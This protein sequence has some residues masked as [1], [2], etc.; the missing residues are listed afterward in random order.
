MDNATQ[1][2]ITH[3]PN[4]EAFRAEIASTNNPAFVLIGDKVFFDVP[5]VTVIYGDNESICLARCNESAFTDL[6]SIAR[7]GIAKNGNFE[8]DNDAAKDAYDRVIAAATQAANQSINLEN[9]EINI[10]VKLGV[11]L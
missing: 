5:T 6:N 2:I 10:Q 3:V 1:D 9:E 11:F 7:I 8:F 4:L